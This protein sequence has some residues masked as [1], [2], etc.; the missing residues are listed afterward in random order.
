MFFGFQNDSKMVKQS[1]IDITLEQG[2]QKLNMRDRCSFE[3]EQLLGG[4]GGT[5]LVYMK[6]D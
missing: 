6:A 5:K 2:K 1:E 4:L 3:P